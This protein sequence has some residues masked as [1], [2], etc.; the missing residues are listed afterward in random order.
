[1]SERMSSSSQLEAW[2]QVIP[3][4]CSTWP[5][6]LTPLRIAREICASVQAPRPVSRSEVRLRDHNVPNGFQLTL[7]PPLPSLV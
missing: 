6:R 1:M 5:L 2:S 3:C 4:Q 7:S